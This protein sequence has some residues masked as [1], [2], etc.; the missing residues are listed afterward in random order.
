MLQR[1]GTA[2]VWFIV[3]VYSASLLFPLYSVLELFTAK[4]FFFLSK[5][6]QK[7]RK[8]SLRNISDRFAGG[9]ESEREREKEKERVEGERVA[10]SPLTLLQSG[11][12]QPVVQTLAEDPDWAGLG[13][14]SVPW[15]DGR[16][17]QAST[18]VSSFPRNGKSPERPFIELR[19]GLYIPAASLS[20]P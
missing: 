11:G 12:E 2:A 16:F 5:R 1:E 3:F 19:P 4:K 9:R 7:G 15:A 6:I 8:T 18:S 20:G 14:S 17:G 10:L 13:G